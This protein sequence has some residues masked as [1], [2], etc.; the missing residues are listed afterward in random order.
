MATSRPI[1]KKC[2]LSRTEVDWQNPGCPNTWPKVTYLGHLGWLTVYLPMWII[3][4]DTLENAVSD[5]VHSPRIPSSSTAPPAVPWAA[6]TNRCIFGTG[7]LE[8]KTVSATRT[9]PVD[10]KDKTEV[11][12]P[13]W[14]TIKDGNFATQFSSSNLIATEWEKVRKAQPTSSQYNL[15]SPEPFR[16]AKEKVGLKLGKMSQVRLG[17]DFQSHLSVRLEETVSQSTT[18]TS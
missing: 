18:L 14:W 3:E 6:A 5:L 2:S 17:R 15:E 9:R 12:M 1:L 8:T 4:H 11:L 10:H 16:K 7:C 13:L